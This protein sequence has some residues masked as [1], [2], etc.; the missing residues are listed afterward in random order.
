MALLE[1]IHQTGLHGLPPQQL[2]SQ[3]AG[4]GLIDRQECPQKT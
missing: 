4:R 2:T 1:I 3:R